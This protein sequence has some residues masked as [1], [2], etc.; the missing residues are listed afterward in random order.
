MVRAPAP[1][2]HLEGGDLAETVRRVNSSGFG[3]TMGLHSRIARAA[4]TVEETGTV[5]NLYVN[6]SMIGAIVGSQPFGG[7]GLSGTGPK[8][9]GPALPPPLLRRAGDQHRHDQRRRQ[10]D[11]AVA[12]GCG[13]LTVGE[14]ARPRIRFQRHRP[15]RLRA[16][17]GDARP[18]VQGRRPLPLFR[19][20]VK[21]STRRCVAAPFGGRICQ[22]RDQ[23]ALS[24]TRSRS[25]A[26]A[27]GPESRVQFL[28]ELSSGRADRDRS[29]S[30]RT[31]FCIRSCS[32]TRLRLEV[33]VPRIKLRGDDP[34]FMPRPY[35]AAFSASTRSVFSQVNRSPSGL[36]PKWP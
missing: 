32:F 18:L 36:R 14:I 35:S 9:G 25:A 6:R 26:G 4:E 24:A 19:R 11:L 20:A 16:T 22:P 12:G 7:E 2:H 3:L 21:R 10:R 34:P 28:P 8:A 31:R 13:A 5:G 27:S 30:W 17:A 29:S 15:R 33:G 23:A 1:R